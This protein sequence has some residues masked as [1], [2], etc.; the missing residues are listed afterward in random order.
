MR[1][2]GSVRV[3]AK[4]GALLDQLAER[5]EATAASLAEL[6]DEPRSSVYRLLA[7]LQALGLVEPGSQR[8][9]YRLGLKI[10]QLGSAV[11]ARF[12]ERQGALPIMERIHE[13]TGET[14]FLCIRR[15]YEAVCI[16][17]LDGRRVQSLA[18]RLGG[19]LPLHAGAAPRVLLAFESEDLWEEYLG[20][21]SLTAFTPATPVGR[22]ELFDRLHETRTLGYAV[23]DEDVTLGIAA[24][25]APIFDHRGSVRAALSISG[26]KPAVL[27]DHA[28]AMAALVVEG[29][30]EVSRSLG[31]VPE[32]AGRNG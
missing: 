6:V 11:L 17:R 5:R 4:A 22:Q 9:T 30:R 18:L 28:D 26:V 19:T 15:E 14:V 8:G 24:V 21:G 3:L 1:R 12:D 31:F 13:E 25:G 29:A 32:P 16:E 2:D 10:F 7:S 27:G 20:Q 23:S